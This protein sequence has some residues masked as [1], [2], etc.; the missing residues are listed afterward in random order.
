MAFHNSGHEICSHTVSHPFLTTLT[1]TQLVFELQHSKQV[2]ETVTGQPVR[3]FA[4]P[5]GDYSQ[6]V[7]NEIRNYY[8]SHRTV[9]EGYNSKD[10]FDAYRLRVQNIFN[11]TTV[12]ELQAWINQAKATN[13]W[14]I[15]VYHRVAADAGRYDSYPA[16][17]AAQL[18]VINQSG[19]TVKT[20]NDA[21]NEI[22]PQL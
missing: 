3:N 20:Y 6:S 14:L 15:L 13:T 19:I 9:D 2:L 5:Y 8:Q 10:N 18:N 1:P 4:S 12:G 7:N 17:F 21:L 16:D 11:T 22:V